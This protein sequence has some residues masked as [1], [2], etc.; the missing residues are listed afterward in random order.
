[1][2]VHSNRVGND[3]NHTNTFTYS[4]KAHAFPNKLKVSGLSFIFRRG[5]K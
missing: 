3:L 1:M 4:R 5:F 2:F